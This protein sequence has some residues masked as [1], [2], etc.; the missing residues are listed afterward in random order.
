MGFL[1]K[2]KKEVANKDGSIVVEILEEPKYFLSTGSYSL[3]KL[4]TGNLA[5]A[6][7][8]GRLTALG[9]HSSSGKSLVAASILGQILEEDGMAV[10]I[11]VEGALSRKYLTSCGVDVDN[12]NFIRISLNRI[13][14]CSNAVNKFIKD[15]KAAG[16]TIPTVIMIDSLDMLLTEG[17]EKQIRI[18]G[19]LAGD[20]GQRAKQ[21]KRMIGPWVHPI[22]SLPISIVCTKQVYKEQDQLK[23]YEEPWVFTPSLEYAFSQIIIF[24]KLQFK[25]KDSEGKV[26]H[27]G[28]TL[29]AKS[30]KNRIAKE[31]QV[32]KVEVPFSGGLDPYAGIVEIA[33]QYEVVTKGGAWYH[34]EGEKFQGKKALETN[35]EVMQRVL[36]AVMKVDTDDREVYANLDDYVAESEKSSRP[37]TAKTK[38]ERLALEAQESNEADE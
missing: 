4:M 38:R 6:I 14:K 18:K 1:D 8:Q 33:L 16:M 22:Q 10:C 35:E 12:P 3:N 5:G 19:E 11:D 20:Q 13:N 17:E 27:L 34:F 7:P 24:E 25:K 15:Y 28:F 23:A 2:Y 32:V 31:K 21:L 30:Y 29:K 37:E 36:K 9:G 26:E